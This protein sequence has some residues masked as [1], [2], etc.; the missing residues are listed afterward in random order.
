MDHLYIRVHPRDNVA[1]IVNSEGTPAGA[2]FSSGLEAR[3]AIPQSHKI[4][5]EGIEAAG[6]VRRYGE[7]IG[8]ATRAIAAGSWVRGEWIDLPAAPPLDRLGLATAVPP[9]PQPL[10]GVTFDGYPNP[11]GGT[12]TKNILGITT[13]VQ[14]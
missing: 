1:I 6:P 3:E 9:P 5:L 4:A 14:C 2:R 8:R 10:A 13:T 12:G 7:V 11:D